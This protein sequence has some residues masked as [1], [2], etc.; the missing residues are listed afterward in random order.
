MIEI[1]PENASDA[2]AIETLL[3]QEFGPGRLAKSSYCYRK[4]VSRLWPLCLVAREAGEI[5]GTIRYWPI[6]IG[7][8]GQPALLLGP[9]AVRADHQSIGVGGLLMRASLARAA[10]AGHRL[11]VLVGD[12]PYYGRFGFRPASEWGISMEGENTARVLALALD[13]NAATIPAGVVQRWR[14]VR[15]EA[16]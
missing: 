2:A 14:S 3:D 9:V 10:A 16:A 12:E 15:R 6:T 5:V 1:T 11:V 4:R 8:G 13:G 7:Q